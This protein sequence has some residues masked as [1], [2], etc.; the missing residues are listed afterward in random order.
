[1][2]KL[3]KNVHLVIPLL[4]VI[5]TSCNSERKKNSV[6]P[7]QEEINAISAISDASLID[8]ANRGELKVVEDL[9]KQGAD[10]NQADQDGRTPLMYAAY[11]GHTETVK[12]LLEHKAFV[13]VTDVNGRTAL[14]FAASGP[15]PVVVGL[16]LD[17]Q[18]DPN[19]A[20]YGEHFTALMYAASEGQL[21]VVNILIE[22]HANPAMKD[23]DGDNALSF[24][25]KNGHS[26]VVK[27]LE[28]Q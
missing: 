26:D 16:L 20:D 11:N 6:P 14:M 19:K 9:L 13:D 3:A 1:M 10:V 15:F 27:F 23:I 8:P 18:A 21:E 25:R 22:H 24:A 28:S 17:Y 7:V 12:L 5:F 2:N 4:L